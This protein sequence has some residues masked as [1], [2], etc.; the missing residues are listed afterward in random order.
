MAL[1]ASSFHA[2][3]AAGAVPR[4]AERSRE[5][6]LAGLAA[7]GP[8]PTRTV[9]ATA[10]GALPGATGA[11]QLPPPGLREPRRSEPAT[12][13]SQGAGPSGAATRAAAGVENM[14]PHGGM[15]AAPLTAAAKARRNARHS[16][17]G[18]SGYGQGTTFRLNGGNAGLRGTTAVAPAGPSPGKY[19]SSGVTANRMGALGDI[20]GHV[21]NVV[22]SSRSILGGKPVKPAAAF[23]QALPSAPVVPTRSPLT[24][25][26]TPP[27]TTVAPA[28]A[29]LQQQQHQQ[30][31]LTA[32]REEEPF[33]AAFRGDDLDVQKVGEYAQ[34]IF[35]Q[36]FQ[37]EEAKMPRLDY[38]EDQRD[39]NSRM[40]GILVD[41]L[42]EVHQKYHM[43]PETLYLA[44]NIGDR[45][46]S[47][48]SVARRNL[49]L[50]GVVTMFI[51]AKFEEI[52]PPKAHEFAFI[53]DNTYTKEDILKMECTVL[54]ALNFEIVVPTQAHFMERLQ[55]VNGCDARHR[56]L[57]EYLLEL[58]LVEIRTIRFPPSMLVS[59]A[60]LLSNELLDI[61]PAWPPAMAHHARRSEAALQAC[62]EELRSVLL[63]APRASLQAVRRKY[64][65]EQYHAVANMSILRILE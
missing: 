55:R 14:A 61:H 19:V 40:R 25:T 51:A 52:D 16:S 6:S 7:G 11:G 49:Q 9:A 23:Y 20:T 54:G 13:Y 5:L 22:Q 58:A 10:M 32:R 59:A 45:Y 60:L 56:A 37:D 27:A 33:S 43:R 21:N 63:A 47:L 46:L 30:L 3:T 34:D 53:T 26:R 31:Q 41:W 42:I 65:L 57:A 8:P 4:G 62:K 39:I 17:G 44:I 18:S 36:L 29:A 24:V 12:G 28:M 48:R 1:T 50:L 2:L 38:M 15:A 64:Q 35:A